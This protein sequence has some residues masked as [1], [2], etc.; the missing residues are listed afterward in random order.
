[1]MF[2]GVLHARVTLAASLGETTPP[3]CWETAP[4]TRGMHA[5]SS[6]AHPPEVGLHESTEHERPSSQLFGTLAQAPE[7]HVSPVVQALPSSQDVPS[8]AAVYEQ[9]PVLASQ[10]PT[11]HGLSEGAHPTTAQ[12]LGFV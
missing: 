4:Q 11:A 9:V 7:A 8:G 6:C 5:A 3:A 10:V 2:P 1:M 12:L